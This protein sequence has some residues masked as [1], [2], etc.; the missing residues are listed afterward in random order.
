MENRS[1]RPSCA[2]VA[3]LAGV[4]QATVSRVFSPSNAKVADATREKILKV[5]G[6]INYHPN[7]IARG[8]IKNATQIVGVIVD[9]FDNSFYTESI[10]H[11]TARLQECGYTAMVFNSNV[12]DPETALPIAMQYQVDGIVL[13][14]S[15]LPKK[16]V[17]R[18]ASLPVPVVSYNRYSDSLPMSAV[19]PD[20]FRIGKDVAEYLAVRGHRRIAFVGGDVTVMP[21]IHDR[22]AGFAQGLSETGLSL[23]AAMHGDNTYQAGYRL[24]Q[25]LLSK[26]TRPD[27]LF[28]CNY[29]VALGAID[30]AR[31]LFGLAVPKD[32][33]VV[34]FYDHPVAE[35]GSY[36]LTTVRLPVADIA[37]SAVDI[38][39]SSIKEKGG[40]V[41]MR[42]F[43]GTIIERESVAAR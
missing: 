28:C 32:M 5:A 39:L 27:A 12:T 25:D 43:P 20:N 22:L 23:F 13:A 24:T 30:A 31:N 16:L 38:L 19:G 11:F 21:P 35:S 17:M 4:S 7:I 6:E 40:D 37:N 3:K 26:K 10:Q 18:C 14:S 29:M 15:T 36:S 42:L 1:S 34:G 2:D 41:T 8:L 33:S 9:R